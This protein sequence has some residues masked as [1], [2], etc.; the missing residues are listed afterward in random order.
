M[1]SPGRFGVGITITTAAALIATGT[2]AGAV[3]EAP[4]GH[5][6][7]RYDMNEGP[8]ARTM[9][10][11]SGHG[12]NGSIGSEVQTGVGVSGATGYRFTRLEP[13]TPPTHPRH[14]ATVP[15]AGDLNPG[16]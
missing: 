8:G 7:A 2:A 11:S 12:L 9:A 4:W 16:D 3:E 15:S 10:D 5:T 6:V 14:L 1:R 13:D